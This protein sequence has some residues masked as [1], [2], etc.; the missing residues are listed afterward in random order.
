MEQGGASRR[1]HEHTIAEIKMSVVERPVRERS[2]SEQGRALVQSSKCFKH[3]GIRGRGGFNVAGECKVKGVD[4]HGFR[5]DGSISVVS[6]GVKVIPP[7]ESISGSHVSPRGDLPDEIKV[8]KKEGPSSLLMRKF[9]R[10]LEIGEILV[11]GEDRDGV[12]S[13]LQVLLP[14]DESE[15]DGEEL[16]IIYVVVAFCGGEGLG[17]VGAGV[18][19]S[20]FIRLH[21][22]GTSGEEGG[23]GHES[24]GVSD[25]WDA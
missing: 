13:S 18:K 16:S 2:T 22:D 11:V 3:K 5:Q 15:D 4:D 25:I 10:V 6:R 12:R 19:V 23:V 9:T 17:E 8:L 1:G 14:F 24:E 7:G 21:Q 20:C